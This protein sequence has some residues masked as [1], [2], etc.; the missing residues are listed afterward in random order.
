MCTKS[1]ERV[2][3]DQIK[4][5]LKTGDVIIMRGARF[6][7]D[8]IAC[9]TSSKF[10]HTAMVARYPGDD[11]I[12]CFCSTP[13]AGHFNSRGEDTWR[14]GVVC[15]KLEDELKSGIYMDCVIRKLKAPLSD[16]KEAKLKQFYEDTKHK[17]YE[18]SAVQLAYS[19]CDCGIWP[20]KACCHN[21]ANLDEYFCSEW[22]AQA[23]QHINVG[24]KHVS[25]WTPDD[26]D[27][28]SSEKKKRERGKELGKGVSEVL[29][30][31]QT[32]IAIPQDLDRS[33]CAIYCDCS[34]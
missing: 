1:E 2:P 12:Y 11:T 6:F 17:K 19:S 22:V 24:I 14:T 10:S 18:Q 32:H 7:S 3:L 31:T 30:P 33:G 20:F 16:E 25:E 29:E 26:F 4:D 13:N 21:S 9:V 5:Q 23:L 28:S 27:A 34:W 15:L 8:A